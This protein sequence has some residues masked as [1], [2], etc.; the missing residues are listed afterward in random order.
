MLL[1][2]RNEFFDAVSAAQAV[3]TAV[4]GDVIDT[5]TGLNATNVLF[6][7]GVSQPLYLVISVDTTYTSGG[8]AT[9]AFS[10]VSDSVSALTGSPTTHWTSLT[11]GFASLVAGTVIVV[12]LPPDFT[13]ERYLGV[14]QTVATAATTGGAVSAYLTHNPRLW[15]AYA[16]AVN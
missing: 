13:Y 15:T 1:D 2:E 5:F 12:P 9:V 3:S 16:D 7:H 10:L 6:G 11:Y 8:A 14:R 4:L